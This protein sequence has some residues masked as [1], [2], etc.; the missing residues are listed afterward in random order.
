MTI[1]H[2]S[3]DQFHGY[4]DGRLTQGE[5]QMVKRHL[6]VCPQCSTAL[7]TL[8]GIDRSLRRVPRAHVSEGFTEAVLSRLHLAPKS[9][10]AFR[11]LEKVAYLFGLSI[12][13]AIMLAAFVI[14]GVVDIG[15]VNQT[16]SSVQQS[17]SAMGEGIDGLVGSLS[18]WL[19]A[20]FPF[21]YSK[22]TLS[23]AFFGSLIV[24]VLGVV[25][26]VFVRRFVHRI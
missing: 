12:V 25:D 4:I 8:Q 20:Y 13:L 6:L 21:A 3:S 17:L 5:M 26:R 11:V 24:A 14:T 1:T 23:I 16:Q 18:T 9:P 2:C 19:K 15:A 7:E 22:G 10:L